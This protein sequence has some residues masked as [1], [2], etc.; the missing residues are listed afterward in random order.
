[1]IFLEEEFLGCHAALELAFVFDEADDAFDEA[2]HAGDAGPG[3]DEIEYS[4]KDVAHVELVDAESAEEDAENAGY[5]LIFHKSSLIFI[6]RKTIFP[7][8]LKRNDCD[9]RSKRQ[10]ETDIICLKT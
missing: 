4:G 5:N 1:M 9:L 2:E 6:I 10:N 3:E 8:S 7:L